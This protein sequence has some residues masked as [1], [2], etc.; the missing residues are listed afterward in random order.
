MRQPI[1]RSDCLLGLPPLDRA[2]VQADVDHYGL[3]RDCKGEVDSHLAWVLGATRGD[4]KLFSRPLALVALTEA[5]DGRPGEESSGRA[6]H[7]VAPRCSRSSASD[8]DL[9]AGS[10]HS[11]CQGGLT[12]D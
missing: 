5:K 6:C 8:R 12:Q 2:T 1:A 11:H 4:G 7:F 10:V 9:L 3:R